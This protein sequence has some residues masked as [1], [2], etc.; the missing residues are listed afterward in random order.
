[1]IL[2]IKNILRNWADRSHFGN[3]VFQFSRSFL[4]KVMLILP[5]KA[6]AKWFYKLYTGKNLN[7]ETPVRFDE[8]VWWL[9]LNNRDPLLTKC[10]DKYEVRDYV[11]NCGY[12]EILIPN[13]AVYTKAQEIVFDNIDSEVVIKSTSGSGEN[14]FLK[15]QN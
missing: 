8:K 12:E 6:Y 2:K 14:V 3:R 4:A 13:L 1:M 10:S 9:K 15:R 5:D 7:L 11:K